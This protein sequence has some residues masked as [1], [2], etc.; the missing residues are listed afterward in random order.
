MT[1]P[2]GGVFV[3][4]GA[5]ELG[6]G[7]VGP[8]GWCWALCSGSV[9][10]V[11]ITRVWRFRVFLNSGAT[12]SMSRKGNCFDNAVIENFFG[13]LKEEVFHHVRYLNI[14]AL[15]T[16]LDEYIHW[17]NHVRISTKL[18]GLSPVQ[19]RTQALAA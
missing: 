6:A 10:G 7:G 13:H 9:V 2:G 8:A 3:E 5:G 1:R 11:L 12:Q 4:W 17:Y 14:D 16:A 18:E 15:A 19:Y